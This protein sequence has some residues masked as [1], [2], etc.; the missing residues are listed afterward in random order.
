MTK[1]RAKKRSRNSEAPCILRFCNNREGVTARVLWVDFSGKE[2]EYARL[3]E[4]VSGGLH[5]QLLRTAQAEF[6][7][8]GG[9]DPVQCYYNQDTYVNHPWRL[10]DAASGDLLAE[11]VRPPML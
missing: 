3:D 5:K 11:C 8:Q 7:Q 6:L 9:C 1:G 4:L 2:K 10:R